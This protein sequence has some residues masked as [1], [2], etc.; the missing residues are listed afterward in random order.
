MGLG[1]SYGGIGTVTP[2]LLDKGAV[3]LAPQNA[4]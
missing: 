2:L 1:I 4:Q 3:L